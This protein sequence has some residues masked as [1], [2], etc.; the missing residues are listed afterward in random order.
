[1]M[2]PAEHADALEARMV[3]VG[4]LNTDRVLAVTSLP[5]P[6]ETVLCLGEVVS[7]GGKGAN[8][9]AASATLGVDTVFIGSVGSDLEGEA[10]LA[11]L[12]RAGVDV[13]LVQRS[14]TATGRATIAVDQE[15]ANLIMVERG[16]NA[17]LEPGHVHQA[18][19]RLVGP[20]S[21]VLASLEV[22][23]AAAIAAGQ[24]ARQAGAN[25]VLNP[26]PAGVLP[27]DV[28]S[29]CDVMV[30]NEVE[31]IQLQLPPERFFAP[32][33]GAL[34][35]T[36]GKEG[37]ELVRFGHPPLIF[38]P[39]AVDVSDTTGAGDTFVAAFCA[40]RTLGLSLE[41]S[42][43]FAV[44]AGSLSTTGTGARGHLPSRSEV[45]NAMTRNPVWS[46]AP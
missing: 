36:R 28:L 40:A 39:L 22:P 4:S 18:V 44:V 43:R 23:L 20:G 6:G 32:G 19:T 12:E 11:E 7:Q 3:V 34:V 27:D 14:A 31:L 21:I 2:L 46:D 45:E 26:S 37:A 38:P 24:A 16:A 15:G 8:Q 29:L 41:S 30:P 13:S 42:C 10:G 1:M 17:A 25:F 9:A 35:V 33:T 5:G